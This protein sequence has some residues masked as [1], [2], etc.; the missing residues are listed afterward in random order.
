MLIRL[1]GGMRSP[2]TYLQQQKP[3]I[4]RAEYMHRIACGTH[5]RDK[6]GHLSVAAWEVPPREFMYYI[7]IT[8]N[9]ESWKNNAKLPALLIATA[10][11]WYCEPCSVRRKANGD[12]S[13]STRN[14]G[15]WTVIKKKKWRAK[16]NL[17]KIQRTKRLGHICGVE[18]GNRIKN[19]N[20]DREKRVPRPKYQVLE[21]R[22]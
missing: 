20:Q 21:D 12:S 15:S 16:R 19:G 6:S 1:T 9:P 4:M 11:P 2:P 8:N 7:M 5:K 22:R 17:I 18:T 14:D 10:R 3:T 13:L